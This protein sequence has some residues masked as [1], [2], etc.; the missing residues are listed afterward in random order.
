MPPG[1]S[2]RSGPLA[3]MYILMLRHFGDLSLVSNSV[4]QAPSQV[5][6]GQYHLGDATLPES[7]VRKAS[8]APHR[9]SL[10]VIGFSLLS[11]YNGEP[12]ELFR[13]AGAYH[14]KTV[15]FS[16]GCVLR[17]GFTPRW[18]QR[19]IAKRSQFWKQNWNSS[20]SSYSI[21]IRLPL[22]ST[23]SKVEL[24]LSSGLFKPPWLVVYY[25][26]IVMD[27]TAFSASA[28]LAHFAISV[29]VPRF[30]ALL[31]ADINTMRQICLVLASGFVLKKHSPTFMLWSDPHILFSALIW[32]LYREATQWLNL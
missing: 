20:H 8:V 29:L 27:I 18:I 21:Q 11:E 17:N 28:I 26:A 31:Y 30:E 10:V 25:P 24:A 4:C 9:A 1:Q 15:H 3:Q 16:K 14:D 13:L 32:K 7:R 5:Q 6:L 23:L 12:H 22:F 19:H 2:V